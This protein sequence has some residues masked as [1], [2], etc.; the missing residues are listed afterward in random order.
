MAIVA[1]SALVAYYNICAIHSVSQPL[2]IYNVIV[3]CTYSYELI[4]SIVN[5]L[6]ECEI[7]LK[8][9]KNKRIEHNPSS[10]ATTLHYFK[11]IVPINFYLKPN[12]LQAIINKFWFGDELGHAISKPRFYHQLV[13]NRVAFEERIPMPPAI[14]EGLKGLG[15]EIFVTKRPEYSAVQAIYVESK[16]KI[17]AKSDPRKYGHTAGF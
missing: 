13:P 17:F 4:E 2:F 11:K 14:Q 12:F 8:N 9:I 3:C 7:A 5:K 16:N 6:F 10:A 15:H 1:K